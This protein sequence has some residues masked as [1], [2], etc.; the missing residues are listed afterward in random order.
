M[1]RDRCD[2][3]TVYS[4][5]RVQRRDG[6]AGTRAQSVIAAVKGAEFVLQ[7]RGITFG[8]HEI[9]EHIVEEGAGLF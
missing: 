7:Q 1:M 2:G 6:Y 3:G 5:G 9:V 8:D 4:D